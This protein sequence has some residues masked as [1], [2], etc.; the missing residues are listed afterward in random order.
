MQTT[1]FRG[2]LV[3][4]GR[5]A[6]GI[7]VPPEVVDALGAGRQPLVVATVGAHTY[8]S[9]VAVRGGEFKLPVSAENRAAAGVEAGDTVDVTLVLD[10]EARTVD[11]PDDLAAALSP[12]ARATFDALSNSRK[13][14][15]VLPIEGA[16]TPETRARR[17]AKAVE[18]LGA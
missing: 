4:A 11:V 9:K 8:R 1:T 12:A 16:K 18:A 10:T 7:T 5:T 15:L 3:L 14:Q 6:T 13:Q 17:V 2:T